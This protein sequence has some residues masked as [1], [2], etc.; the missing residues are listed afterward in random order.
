[1]LS[2]N[3]RAG[4]V[5]ATNGKARLAVSSTTNYRTHYFDLCGQG[6][7]QTFTLRWFVARLASIATEGHFELWGGQGG[8]I[9]NYFICLLYL[10]SKGHDFFPIFSS[11]HICDERIMIF[12]IFL[13]SSYICDKGVMTFAN[14]FACLSYMRSTGHVFCLFVCLFSSRS[15]WILPS[16]SPSQQLRANIKPKNGRE[17]VCCL[18][19]LSI[20]GLFLS[21]QST[22]IWKRTSQMFNY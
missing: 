7:K 10:P 1:M 15:W 12:A 19:G 4:L 11:S 16:I 3:Q 5:Q 9:A 22:T 21:I 20:K 2:T 18:V 8:I 13:F 17:L 14:Y 6:S